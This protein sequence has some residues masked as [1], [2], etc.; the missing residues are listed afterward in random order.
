MDSGGR[1]SI[2]LVISPNFHE[3]PKKRTPILSLHGGYSFGRIRAKFFPQNYF[4]N[5]TEG[6]TKSSGPFWAPGSP[7]NWVSLAFGCALEGNPPLIFARGDDYGVK[8][9]KFFFHLLGPQEEVLFPNQFQA[10]LPSSD[11]LPI[12]DSAIFPKSYREDFWASLLGVPPQKFGGQSGQ[13]GGSITLLGQFS[14]LNKGG[15]RG[16]FQTPFSLREGESRFLPAELG[17][18]K[19]FLS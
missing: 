3:N 10:G 8:P 16:L 2:I 14:C 9:L 15:R 4:L 7:E 13:G 19:S 1:Y 12:S 18:G 6:G 5:W 11:F 17:P